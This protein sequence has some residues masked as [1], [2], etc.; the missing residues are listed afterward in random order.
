MKAKGALIG[1]GAGAFICVLGVLDFHHVQE[2]WEHTT[3]HPDWEMNGACALILLGLL[4]MVAFAGA[5]LV[6]KL[7]RRSQQ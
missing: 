1:V 2:A 6:G 5:G 3:F 4:S 7:R